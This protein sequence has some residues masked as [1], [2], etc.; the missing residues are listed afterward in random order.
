[1]NKNQV[2]HFQENYFIEKN[3]FNKISM[4]QANVIS[5][6]LW[7]IKLVYIFIVKKLN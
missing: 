1:M 2:G 6:A 4:S 7:F 5:K 3:L